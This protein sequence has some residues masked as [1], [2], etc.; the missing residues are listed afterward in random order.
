MSIVVPNIAQMYNNG[1]ERLRKEH[2]ARE[3]AKVGQFRGGNTG[4]LAL[5]GKVVGACGRLTYLRWKGIRGVDEP[6]DNKQLMFDAGLANED[7]WDKVL[8]PELTEG[9]TMLREEEI[10]IQ[11]KL[12]EETLVS[13]RPDAV[14]CKQFAPNEGRDGIE[15]SIPVLGL[16]YKL[17]S[18]L[19]TGRDV[20]VELEPKIAHLMQAGHYAWA[21]GQQL[22]SR[23]SEISQGQGEAVTAPAHSVYGDHL[24][25]G[26]LPYEL[27]Y[28][29]RAEF[30]IGSGWEQNVF[31]KPVGPEHPLIERGVKKNR[32]GTTTATSKK[33]LQFR[34]GYRIQF[35]KQGQ[36]QYCVLDQAGAQVSEWRNTPVTIKGLQAYYSAVKAQDAG[37][38]M[39]PPVVLKADGSDGTYSPCDYCEL[40]EICKSADKKKMNTVEWVRAVQTRKT[41]E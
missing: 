27:W 38:L 9:Y 5:G 19:W 24:I 32:N 40:K 17:V 37:G 4:I 26:C 41:P 22:V 3:V 6:G 33:L 10:P 14:V 39:P 12:D 8:R 13:G 7:I 11:W 25:N 29:N 16:E 21:L 20:G 2:E 15:I 36:L 35:T 1:I 30:A 18:S 31:P 34:Q 28:T 23:L